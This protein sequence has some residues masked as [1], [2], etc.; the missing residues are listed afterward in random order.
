MN[1]SAYIIG[2]IHGC[3]DKLNT[4]YS[5]ISS[6]VDF[7][8]SK[9]IFVGDYI[10]RG[11]DSAGVIDMVMKLQSDSDNVIA[12]KGNHEMM[13][14]DSDE[15]GDDL[16]MFLYNGGS[17]TLSSYNF[18]E[19]GYNINE[20]K[21]IVGARH[22]NWM[23]NLP[24]Y[25]EYGE[26]AVAHAGIDMEDLLAGEHTEQQLLWSRKLRKHPHALYKFTVHGHTPMNEAFINQYVAYIDT[27]A[28]F[29]GKLTCLY[30]P[31]VYN[32]IYPEMELIQV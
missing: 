1:K 3:L 5:K 15:G 10:D 17:Q 2:D 20:I 29:G 32:P 23:K 18:I 16:G 21:E 28:V 14:V 11:P 25:C 12:L 22:F 24:T 7:K 26:V 30:I 6:R 8:N 27:G 4:L 9:L 31:D 19:N 13:L